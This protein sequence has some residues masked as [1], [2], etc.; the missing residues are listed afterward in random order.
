MRSSSPDSMSL[1]RLP[2]SERRI[3]KSIKRRD[4]TL[5]NDDDVETRDLRWFA[6]Q[7][8]TPSLTTDT[9]ERLRSPNRCEYEARKPCVQLRNG[10]VQCRVANVSTVW[11]GEDAIASPERCYGSTASLRIRLAEDFEQIPR[12]K[13]YDRV[14]HG[15]SP[16]CGASGSAH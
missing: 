6:D 16:A 1:G 2:K 3:E 9:V 11:I 10:V 5:L 13:I 14:S 7:P 12:K 4:E 15:S 8:V